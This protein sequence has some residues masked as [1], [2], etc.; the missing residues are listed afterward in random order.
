MKRH[1]S[2]YWGFSVSAALCFAG[3]IAGFC[4]YAMGVNVL[5]VGVIGI[6]F[7]VVSLLALGTVI[8][9]DNL[10]LH[11]GRLCEEKKYEEER[12]L[13]ERKM[14]SPFFFLY[15]TVA[16]KRYIRVNMA[17]DDLPTAKRAID[18]LRH[19][20][21]AGWKYMTAFFFILIKLDEGDRETARTEYE[22]FRTQCAHAEIYKEQIEILTA[23]FRRIFGTNNNEPLPASVV[24]APFPVIG[25]VLGRVYEERAA[26]NANVWE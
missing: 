3:A 20:G 9:Q 4:A 8:G 24:G 13:I 21:G 2:L 15:R 1:I 25:R 7:G 12:A 11:C 22:E 16:L 26:E 18:I 14:K 5:Y 23:V 6:V 17:L 19:G 10:N